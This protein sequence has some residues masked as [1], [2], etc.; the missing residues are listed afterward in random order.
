[1]YS[2]FIFLTTLA[3]MELAAALLHRH[4][5]HGWGWRWHASHHHPRTGVFETNDLYAL[6]FAAIAIV[7]IWFGTNGYWPLQWVGAGMTAYGFLYF[8]VHDGLVHRRLPMSYTPRKGYLRRLY[9]AHLLHHAV[10]EKH[11]AVSFGFLYAQ[12]PE[13]LKRRLDHLKSARTNRRA[14]AST[15]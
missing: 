5:M 11:G 2:F 8:L 15:K 1:M 6:V 10:H 12:R 9:Q 13:V 4:V 14:A 3:L 7:L